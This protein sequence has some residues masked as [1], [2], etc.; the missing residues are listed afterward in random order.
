MFRN[1][2]FF[3]LF[4][5][6]AMHAGVW[7]LASANPFNNFSPPEAPQSAEKTAKRIVFLEPTPSPR[8]PLP[9]PPSA[10]FT[11]PP[12]DKAF[13]APAPAPSPGRHR[14]SMAAPLPPTPTGKPL[15]FDKTISFSPSTNDGPPM[16][17]DNCLPDPP[18]FSNPV[19][20]DGRSSQMKAAPTPTAQLD[21]QALADCLH[22]LPK[23]N[24]EIE[25]S[26]NA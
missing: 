19:T 15:I 22:L 8:Q 17:R 9:E 16:Y 6:L 1:Q 11:A 18:V 7:L 5:T 14:T 13:A 20:W 12:P 3:A 4:L 25:N 23:E 10:P 26:S 2:H 21:P 24:V